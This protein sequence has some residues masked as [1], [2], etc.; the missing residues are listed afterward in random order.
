M[1]ITHVLKGSTKTCHTH[2]NPKPNA[3]SIPRLVTLYHD[4][5]TPALP[6][7]PSLLPISDGLRKKF[8][9]RSSYGD[10]RDDSEA[11]AVVT[12]PERAAKE[13]AGPSWCRS[14]ELSWRRGGGREEGG[15]R[16]RGGRGASAKRYHMPQ[17]G[18]GLGGGV[19]RSPFARSVTG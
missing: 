5:A 1:K 14:K 4:G 9:D 10:R 3:K 7:A 15:R 19:T 11:K 17:W 16:G 12:P 6:C 2:P 13:A 8:R 18:G